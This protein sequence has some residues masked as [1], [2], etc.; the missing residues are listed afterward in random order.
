M[1]G[2]TLAYVGVN[3][4]ILLSLRREIRL[5]GIAAS[6]AS[7]SADIAER[8]LKLSERAD[9]LLDAASIVNPGRPRIDEY[10]YVL[11]VFKNFGRT[12]AKNVIFDFHIITPDTHGPLQPPKQAT[13]MG[14]GDTVNIRFQTFKEIL[15]QETFARV[16]SEAWCL[17]LQGQSYL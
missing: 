17:A 10:S 1:V 6:A 12:R 8:A 7:K 9:V 14:A 2:L 13:T 16:M 15:T 11:L 3:I 5:T 4:A